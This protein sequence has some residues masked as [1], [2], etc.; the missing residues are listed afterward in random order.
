MDPKALEIKESEV[1]SLKQTKP[2]ISVDTGLGFTIEMSF[3]GPGLDW[4]YA[5]NFCSSS[6]G[7]FIGSYAGKIINICQ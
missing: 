5:A 4:I 6:N 2:D 3:G 7:V 1:V